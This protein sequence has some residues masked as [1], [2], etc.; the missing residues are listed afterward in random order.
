MTQSKSIIIEC[1]KT[2]NKEFL[3]NSMEIKPALF[4]GHGGVIL[5]YAYYYQFTHEEVYLKVCRKLLSRMLKVIE[6]EEILLTFCDGLAG[7]GWLIQHLIDLEIIKSNEYNLDEFDKSLIRFAIAEFKKGNYDFLH[8]GIGIG[9]YFINRPIDLSLKC[10]QKIVNFL[11]N[12][13][14][15]ESKGIYWLDKLTTYYDNDERPRVNFGMA[16]GLPSII[17]F[18]SKAYEHGILKSK[19]EYLLRGTI[20]FIMSC[21]TLES[22]SFFQSIYVIDD[23]NYERSR[24][25]W[26]YGDLSVISSFF[27]ASKALNDN[28]LF[29]ETLNMALTTAKR[30]EYTDTLLVDGGICH[31]YAGVSLIFRKFYDFTH[32]STFSEI[33]NYW[34]EQLIDEI[35]NSGGP[36]NFR[37]YNSNKKTFSKSYDFLTGVIGASFL[38]LMNNNFQMG[39]FEKCLLLK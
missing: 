27:I 4:S 16:H 1:E 32:E 10:I 13:A 28:H 9:I 38:M 30:I 17:Y 29:N 14:V 12:S 6:K 23:Q 36:Q 34:Y 39:D 5:F 35:N 21:R 20:N 11:Y 25:A 8:G 37:Q 19:V 2:I 3:L 7:I 33:S 18:L 22:G 24:L 31:G 15:I 26:C